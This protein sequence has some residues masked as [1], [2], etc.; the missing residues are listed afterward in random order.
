MKTPRTEI[1]Q[2]AVETLDGI[3][4]THAEINPAYAQ[5]TRTPEVQK[6]L[7]SIFDRSTAAEK[8]Y[9]EREIIDRVKA[10]LIACLATTEHRQA[11]ENGDVNQAASRM[12]EQILFDDLG[13]IDPRLITATLL[14]NLGLSEYIAPKGTK[15][16]ERQLMHIQA[17]P[18]IRDMFSQLEP[19]LRLDEAAGKQ[20]KYYRIMRIGKGKNEGYVLGTQ[21][22]IKDKN[23]HQKILFK[24]DINGAALR[25]EHIRQGYKD[26]VEKL[27]H[28]QETLETIHTHLAFW[29]D[30]KQTE[31]LEE[32]KKEMAATAE[33]LKFVRDQDKSKLRERIEDSMSL[34][35]RTGKLNPGAMRAHLL[36]TIPIIGGRIRTM[37]EVSANLAQDELRIQQK[38][39]SIKAPIGQFLAQVERHRDTQQQARTKKEKLNDLRNLLQQTDKMNFEPYRSFAQNFKSNLKQLIAILEKAKSEPGDDPARLFLNLFILA[40][41]QRAYEKLQKIYRDV[42]LNGEKFDPVRMKEELQKMSDELY[43]SRIYEGREVRDYDKQ[44]GAI[45]HIINSLH[46]CCDEKLGHLDPHQNTHE[47]EQNM[48]LHERMKKRMNEYIPNW[49]ELARSLTYPE[50]KEELTTS[51]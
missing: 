20:K 43:E 34:R 17:I 35:D 39:Q 1:I 51:R 28:I 14:E 46:K 10:F 11:I 25:I 31:Q 38:V 18:D 44:V 19:I 2:Q 29:Q 6:E 15:R 45:Y 16:A 13:K 40:K 47:D 27:G 30:I 48:P 33:S 42:T 32:L 23:K 49:A 21:N 4:Q 7:D 41:F 26:E 50:K 22:A 37:S 8:K 3:F 12:T 24:T 9:P 5:E 36:K